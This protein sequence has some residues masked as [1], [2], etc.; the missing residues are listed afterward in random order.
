M[1]SLQFLAW[2]IVH[3]CIP[4]FAPVALLPLL[5]VARTF[6]ASAKGIVYNAIKNGQLLWTGIAM[7]AGACYELAGYLEHA[8]THGRAFAWICLM[9]CIFIMTISAVLV[10]LGAID[11]LNE[12]AE[13]ESAKPS[14]IMIVSFLLTTASAVIFGGAH[15]FFSR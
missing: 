14:R 8:T 4:I 10:M 9:G 15:Y 3:I 6:R 11:G 12:N 1:E 2:A 13:Q 7:S 5:G